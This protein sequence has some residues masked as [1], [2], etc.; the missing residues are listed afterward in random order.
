MIYVLAR[1]HNTTDYSK[2]AKNVRRNALRIAKK[3][4]IQRVC[5]ICSSTEELELD[6]IDDNPMNNESN[7]L[8]YLC[9]P[10]HMTHHSEGFR[11]REDYQTCSKCNKIRVCAPSPISNELM[12]SAC[13]I[14]QCGGLG[15]SQHD[16]VLPS[17][18]TKHKVPMTWYAQWCAGR[19]KYRK[20]LTDEMKKEFSKRIVKGLKKQDKI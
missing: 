10:C 12:C 1:D 15:F 4:G 9:K 13:F 7:N 6:H 18:D 19:P 11:R 2:K 20:S 14:K 3:L 5:S 17:K 8:R 16:L